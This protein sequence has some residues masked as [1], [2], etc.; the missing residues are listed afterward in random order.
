M[1]DG[2]MKEG[3]EFLL[4]ITPMKRIS[5]PVEIARS[6]TYLLADATFTTGAALPADGRF[7]VS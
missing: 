7:S 6:V 5:A 1:L 3:R 4:G 2:V